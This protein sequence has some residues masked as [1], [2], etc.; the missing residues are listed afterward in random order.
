MGLKYSDII[1]HL[2]RINREWVILIL[3]RKEYWED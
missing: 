3:N 1:I 2:D